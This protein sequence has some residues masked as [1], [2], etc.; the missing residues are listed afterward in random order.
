MST[1]SQIREAIVE[2]LK[3][4]AANKPSELKVQASDEIVT[5]NGAIDLDDLV[6]VVLGSVAGGP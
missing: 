2:E 4:Q 1:E 6:M 3:R 5:V